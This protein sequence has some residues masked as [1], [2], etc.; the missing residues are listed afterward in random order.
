M[1]DLFVDY[2]N[3]TELEKFTNKLG[4]LMKEIT[5]ESKIKEFEEPDSTKT[6]EFNCIES[7]TI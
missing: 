2:T 3:A 4:Q 5:E 6:S 7:K 1:T